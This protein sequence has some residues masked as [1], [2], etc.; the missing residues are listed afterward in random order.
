PELGDE[1]TGLH[2]DDSSR[3]SEGQDHQERPDYGDRPTT[4][5][6]APE[7]QCQDS[8]QRPQPDHRVEGEMNEDRVGPV[9]GR[10]LVQAFDLGIRIESSEQTQ[11]PGY[12]EPEDNALLGFERDA[13]DVKGSAMKRPVQPLH[14]S[15][16]GGLVGVDE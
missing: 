1:P 5:G 10:Y 8:K 13:A 9:R 3:A 16:L 2:G 7:H 15:E 11:P 6:H 12:L 14:G 4:P